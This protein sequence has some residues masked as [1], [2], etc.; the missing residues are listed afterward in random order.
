[1]KGKKQK[2]GQHKEPLP[3]VLALQHL[4]ELREA[5]RLTQAQ[6]SEHIGCTV[7]SYSRYENGLRLPRLD[8]VILLAVFFDVSVDYLLGLEKP[9]H[10]VLSEYE[11]H[12]V[13]ASRRVDQ[14]ARQ[15]ALRHLQ[16]SA[17]K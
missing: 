15:D 3:Q 12:L 9:D 10:L 7:S 17:P 6:V 11:I 5:R 14:R 13:E 16:W 4:R 8:V 1:M 2:Q